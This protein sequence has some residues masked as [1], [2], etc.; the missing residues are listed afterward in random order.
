MYV[1]GEHGRLEAPSG[2]FDTAAAYRAA[3]DTLIAQATTENK[4]SHACDVR[5]G[6]QVVGVLAAAEESLRSGRRVELPG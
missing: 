2:Q 6:A 3:L 5:F 1:Y 4:P